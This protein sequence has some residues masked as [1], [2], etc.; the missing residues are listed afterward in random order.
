MA[1]DDVAGG[2]G[3]GSVRETVEMA[4]SGLTQPAASCRNTAGVGW[5]L[6][7]A[8]HSPVNAPAAVGGCRASCRRWARPQSAALFKDVGLS[9]WFLGLLDRLLFLDTGRFSAVNGPGFLKWCAGSAW[10]AL[11]R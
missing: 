7:F 8:G 9:G 2:C 6:A 5:D 3:Q 4:G 10:K 1:A 11:F